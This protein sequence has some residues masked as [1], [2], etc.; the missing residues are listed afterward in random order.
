MPEDK[1]TPQEPEVEAPDATPEETP[2]AEEEA[3]ADALE[4]DAAEGAEP[5]PS[6]D[7]REPQESFDPEQAEADAIK[8]DVEGKEALDA[9]NPAA[10]PEGADQ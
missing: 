10:H 4:Q 9:S 2:T 3:Q 1:D 5:A 7:P 6:F 8:A